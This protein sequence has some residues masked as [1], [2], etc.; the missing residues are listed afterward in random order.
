ML[1]STKQT[2]SAGLL[3]SRESASLTAC[4][5]LKDSCGR[6]AGGPLPS[7]ESEL[8][9]FE[10]IPN[11]YYNVAATPI[12]PHT[13]TPLTQNAPS[14]SFLKGTK[15][16]YHNSSKI[17]FD[18]PSGRYGRVEGRVEGPWTAEW[19]ARVDGRVD[20]PCSWW[21]SGHGGAMGGRAVWWRQPPR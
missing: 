3:L 8:I 7:P 2:G 9:V 15:I 11:S 4:A 13:H 5:P 10:T 20:G 21:W 17:D 16:L 6:A 14:E 18:G 12:K 19:T 1:C